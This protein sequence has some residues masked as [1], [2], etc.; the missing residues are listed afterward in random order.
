MRIPQQR[1][2]GLTVVI[3]LAFAVAG[4]GGEKLLRTEGQLL[5]GGEPFIPEE[6]QHIQIT[7]VPIMKNGKQ[8]TKTYYA[9]VD[10]ETGIFV[11]DGP[12]KMGMPPGKYRVVVA[13]MQKKVDLLDGKFD[14]EQSPFIV[15]VDEDTSEII[16]DLDKTAAEQ[17]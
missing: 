13:L 3:A 7:F 12:Q 2:P 17:T 16:I 9:D 10:Q 5:K 11:P 1:L 8:P 6:G 14:E 4:C 15:D